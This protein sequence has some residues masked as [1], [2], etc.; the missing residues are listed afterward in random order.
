MQTLMRYAIRLRLPVFTIKI[1]FIGATLTL[2]IYVL[3]MQL[4]GRV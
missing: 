1:V 3:K 4:D 2:K